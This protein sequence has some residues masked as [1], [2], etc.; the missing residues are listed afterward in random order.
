ML[1]ADLS[2]LPIYER[3]S[4]WQREHKKQPGL[5]HY[6]KRI[7]WVENWIWNISPLP[8]DTVPKHFFTSSLKSQEIKTVIDTNIN[9]CTDVGTARGATGPQPSLIREVKQELV[10]QSRHSNRN[11]WTI[12]KLTTKLNWKL[13][14]ETH[15]LEEI[16]AEHMAEGKRL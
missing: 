15:T 9:R 14:M 5:T 13:N 3:Y 11:S 6:I 2:K 8:V 10:L 12:S 16:N 7:N 1:D 4:H